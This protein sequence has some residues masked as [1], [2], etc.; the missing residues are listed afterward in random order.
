MTSG[1]RVGRDSSQQ[2]LVILEQ[3]SKAGNV[4]EAAITAAV[5]EETAVDNAATTTIAVGG[6]TVTPTLTA[7]DPRLLSQSSREVHPGEASLFGLSHVLIPVSTMELFFLRFD[8]LQRQLDELKSLMTK[9]PDSCSVYPIIS[10]EA[11]QSM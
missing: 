9:S 7:N 4:D 10:K 6:A 5:S 1:A 8:M 2:A 3:P 11:L